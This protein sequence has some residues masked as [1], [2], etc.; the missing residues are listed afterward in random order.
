M[1][2]TKFEV[3]GINRW[4]GI[5]ESFYLASRSYYGALMTASTTHMELVIKP[6]QV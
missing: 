3:V 1:K 4:S 2:C 5:R 6:H